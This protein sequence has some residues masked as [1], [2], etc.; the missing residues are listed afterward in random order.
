MLETRDTSARCVG[1]AA[2]Q[3]A[4]QIEGGCISETADK[5][6]RRGAH[7]GHFQ[8]RVMSARGSP[9]CHRRQEVAHGCI[10]RRIGPALYPGVAPAVGVVCTIGLA[11]VAVV[12][13]VVGQPRAI[14]RRA[15]L[16][17]AHGLGARASRP[18][19]REHGDEGE[20]SEAARC[21]QTVNHLG[22]RLR[23]SLVNEGSLGVE[24]ERPAYVA[25]VDA[26]VEIGVAALL[27]PAC[28]APA[29]WLR[30][31]LATPQLQCARHRTR[32][33]PLAVGRR[34]L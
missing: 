8:R 20:H 1:A 33:F 24:F 28:R 17:R 7:G 25:A 4:V 5:T 2:H 13:R 27:L 29:A 32:S 21:L 26:S 16:D 31:C 15:G 23:G 6:G 22:R 3:T 18:K 30:C 14:Q 10:A 19:Q 34:W 11:L 12:S 9:A